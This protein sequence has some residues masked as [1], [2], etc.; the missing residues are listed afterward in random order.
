MAP[1]VLTAALIARDEGRHL[2]DCL[3]SLA[4]VVDDIVVV[5][6]GSTDT[7][8]EIAQAHG[9][10]V[11]FEPWRDDFAAARNA[12]LDR[13]GGDWILYIDA[14]ERVRDGSAARLRP[15]LEDETLGA[16]WVQLV[17]KAGHRPYREMRL[18]R[19]D[20]RVRFHGVIHE[21]IWPALNRYLQATGRGVGTSEVVLDHVGYEGDQGHKHARN[22]PLLVRA[23]Q[24]DPNHVYCWTHLAA[25]RR[26]TGDLV[27]AREAL[28]QG[29]AAARRRRS[30]PEQDA[31]AFLELA[32]IERVE[33]RDPRP[34]LEEVLALFPGNAQA[35]FVRAQLNLDD[36][37]IDEAARDFQALVDWPASPAAATTTAGHAE[38]LF[39][40]VAFE[41]LGACRWR[42]GRFAEAAEWFAKS[43][44]WAPDRIE[45]AGKEALC[46][47]LAAGG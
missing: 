9:A 12:A 28:V 19:S 39:D 18:F 13:C 32:D 7:T 36:G 29:V 27:A 1:V 24:D 21:N 40:A 30:G 11:S 10:R 8:P 20:P 41:G 31:L 5:D 46:R 33:G 43:R 44:A 26:A 15:L 38:R 45:L 34:L 25:I 42:A 4:G 2:G 37:R 47:R 3:A 14:D 23:L 35:L 16:C 22:L 17:A 6:T